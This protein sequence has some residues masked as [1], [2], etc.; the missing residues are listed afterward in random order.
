MI[1]RVFYRIRQ[2][3]RAL[4]PRVTDSERHAAREN[5]GADL[6]PL[7]ASMAPA[8]QRHCLDLFETLLRSGRTDPD[9]LKAAL[10]HD[11]GKGGAA[12]ITIPDRIA[13][14]VLSQLPPLLGLAARVSPGMR[15]LRDHAERTLALA[16]E[17]GAPEGVIDLLEQMEGKRE[18]DSRGRALKNADDA[19]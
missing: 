17:H 3:R 2:L 18:M 13:Y 7:F 10:I 5:L 8:D 11:C 4:N 6:H 12:R 9:M 19:T 15:A 14:V 16:R 1:G